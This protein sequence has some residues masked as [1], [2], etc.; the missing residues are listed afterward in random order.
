MDFVTLLFVISNAAF[1]LIPL[2]KV[3]P[4]ELPSDD[5]VIKEEG[6]FSDYITRDYIISSIYKCLKMIFLDHF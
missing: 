3:C 2:L 6:K 1:L 4:F 5:G